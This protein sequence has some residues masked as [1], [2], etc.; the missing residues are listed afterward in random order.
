M[1]NCPN[2]PT[3]L[4]QYSWRSLELRCP[5][6]AV[7]LPRRKMDTR[8]FDVL[9]AE[10]KI[11]QVENFEKGNQK[12]LKQ[13]SDVVQIDTYLY[14]V[15]SHMLG[16]KFVSLAENP[17]EKHFC[18]NEICINARTLAVKNNEDFECKH[19]KLVLQSMANKTLA[20]PELITRRDVLDTANQG[21]GVVQLDR[22]KKHIAKTELE[23]PFILLK[24]SS[25]VFTMT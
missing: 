19:V 21:N 13:I 7:T 23:R 25:R 10:K 11:Q 8:T 6:C 9:K 4:W 14:S 20:I 18:D 1:K 2:Y 3:C 24:L 17:S 12:K 22:I 5:N 15:K 16:R